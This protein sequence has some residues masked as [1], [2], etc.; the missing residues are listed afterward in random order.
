MRL[1]N[2]IPAKFE[3]RFVGW[4]PKWLSRVQSWILGWSLQILLPITH[5]SYCKSL[6]VV[7]PRTL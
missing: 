6:P 3:R 4:N 1:Q 2:E 5:D 7:D